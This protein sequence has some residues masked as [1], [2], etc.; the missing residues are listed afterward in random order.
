MVAATSFKL[1]T[2]TSPLEK[3]EECMLTLHELVLF[4]I[5]RTLMKPHLINIKTY[6]N[7]IQ[8]EK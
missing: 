1:F 3:L 2:Y 7:V 5:S 4:K 6:K 8:R